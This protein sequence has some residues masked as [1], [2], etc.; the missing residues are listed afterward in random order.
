MSTDSG[1]FGEAHES[2]IR[3]ALRLLAS[4][5]KPPNGLQLKA[6]PLIDLFIRNSKLGFTLQL[7]IYPY[8]VLLTYIVLTVLT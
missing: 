2:L 7:T 8:D 3:T 6:Q 4:R 1:N 5:F